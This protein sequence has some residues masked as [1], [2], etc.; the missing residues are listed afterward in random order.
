MLND[1]PSSKRSAVLLVDDEHR[2]VRMFEHMVRH[3]AEAEAAREGPVTPAQNQQ[4]NPLLCRHTAEGLAGIVD[5]H[6]DAQLGMDVQVTEF[7]VEFA[8]NV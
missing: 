2:A 1:K 4:V 7:V 5:F 3:R 6:P 8:A